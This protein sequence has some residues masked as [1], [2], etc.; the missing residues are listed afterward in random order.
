MITFLNSNFIVGLATIITGLVAMLIY[1]HQKK[2]AKK[3]AARVLLLEIRTAEEQISQIKNIVLK[4]ALADFPSIFTTNSWKK[5]SHLFISNFDQDELKLINSFYNYGELI[6]N[7][8]KRNN[9]FF[10][11]TTEERGRTMVKKLSD[12]IVECLNND[13]ITNK[14]IH[15][16]DKK[17]LLVYYLDKYNTPYKPQR[18]IS[19]INTYIKE[20]Q[21]ITTSSC[22][23]KLKKIAKLKND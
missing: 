14:D 3:Q 9:E 21:M 17:D 2:D 16:Q 6:E 1:F 20:I 12:I 23:I 4:G 7:F 10:W 18:S 8:A 15:I 11:V 22:G 13:S 19:E 5:Y